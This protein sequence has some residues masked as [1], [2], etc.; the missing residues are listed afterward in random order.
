MKMGTITIVNIKKDTLIIQYSD[1]SK[2]EIKLSKVTTF[3]D[4]DT[5][6]F[7]N[8][9][10][11]YQLVRENKGDK[12]FDKLKTILD[13]YYKIKPEQESKPAPTVEEL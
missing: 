13:D 1:N 9:M 5:I 6:Y 2:R 10:F 4:D 8:R 12:V 7:E 11:A 3:V